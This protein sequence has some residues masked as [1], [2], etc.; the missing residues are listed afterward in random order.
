MFTRVDVISLLASIS[1]GCDFNRLGTNVSHFE[2]KQVCDVSGMYIQRNWEVYYFIVMEYTHGIT[3]PKLLPHLA[4]RFLSFKD[5]F[6]YIVEST[7]PL[8]S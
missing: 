6:W 5:G 1:Q 4:S 3:A 7:V 8:V 2:R